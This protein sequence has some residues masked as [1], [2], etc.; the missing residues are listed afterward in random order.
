MSLKESLQRKLE[1]QTEEWSKR[2]ESLRADAERRMAEAEDEK[3][4]AQIQREFSE[5]IQDLEDKIEAAR[6]KLGEIKDSSEDQLENL[7][8]HIE[9]WLPSNAN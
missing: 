9:D 7:K 2:I 3:A 4:E 6:N 5:R 8:K 1:T